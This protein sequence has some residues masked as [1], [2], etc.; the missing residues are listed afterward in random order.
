M[1]KEEALVELEDTKPKELDT[2]ETLHYMKDPKAL[3]SKGSFME[4]QAFLTSFI[5][6]IDFEPGQIAIA[7]T[8]SMPIGKDKASE[9]EVLSIRRFGSPGRTRTCNQ[10]VNSRPLYR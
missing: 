7:Y 3:L 10:A 4:Q 5:R 6:T 2:D 9:R 1:A 8:I